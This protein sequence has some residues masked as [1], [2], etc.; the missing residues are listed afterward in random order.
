MVQAHAAGVICNPAPRLCKGS[1]IA[2]GGRARGYLIFVVAA[3]S[4]FRADADT[5]PSSFVYT[6]A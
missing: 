3:R 6:P 4:H 5:F 1:G 2:D